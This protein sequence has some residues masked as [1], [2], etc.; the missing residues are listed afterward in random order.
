MIDDYAQLRSALWNST[1]RRQR[2]L[3]LVK[4]ERD[5]YAGFDRLLCTLPYEQTIANKHFRHDARE[6]FSGKDEMMNGQTTTETAATANDEALIYRVVGIYLSR[7]L[8][9]KYQLDWNAVKDNPK[10]K[11]RYTEM[12][13]KLAREAFLAIR[14]R[15]GQDFV[16]YFASTLCSVAQNMDEQSYINLTQALLQRTDE[17]RTLTMLALSARS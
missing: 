4:G 2:V 3:N 5:W 1:F 11:D 15:T 17:V 9:S 13:E 7:R 16:E 14:S 8:K 6:S 10:E 12:R